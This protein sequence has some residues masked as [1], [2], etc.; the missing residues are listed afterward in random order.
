MGR[1]NGNEENDGESKRFCCDVCL[2]KNAAAVGGNLTDN[3]MSIAL[4]FW[5]TN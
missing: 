2:I 4:K 5:N 3:V 1:E